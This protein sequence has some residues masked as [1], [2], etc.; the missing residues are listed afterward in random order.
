[1]R[2]EKSRCLRSHPAERLRASYPSSGRSIAR[3]MASFRSTEDGGFEAP[4][5]CSQ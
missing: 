1:M 3:P 5:A 4:V 2:M